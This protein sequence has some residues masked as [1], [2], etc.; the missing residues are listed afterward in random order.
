MQNWPDSLLRFSPDNPRIVGH[1]ENDHKRA[2][3]K[4]MVEGSA[5]SAQRLPGNSHREKT[6]REESAAK[7]D[8]VSRLMISDAPS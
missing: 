8:N 1:P 5:A 4:S 2:S 3:W 7:N 6:D